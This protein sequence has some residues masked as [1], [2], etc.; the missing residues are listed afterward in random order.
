VFAEGMRLLRVCGECV[1]TDADL[2]EC[3]RRV[4]EVSVR[5]V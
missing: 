2:R 1:L 3:W 4:R 5:K